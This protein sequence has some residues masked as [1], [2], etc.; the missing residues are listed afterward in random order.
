MTLKES[1]GEKNTQE[2]TLGCSSSCT[3][4]MLSS[5]GARGSQ[6]K[7]ERTKGRGWQLAPS[8]PEEESQPQRVAGY[9]LQ[10]FQL[11]LHQ[12][13]SCSEQVAHQP[14][15]SVILLWKPPYLSLRLIWKLQKTKRKQNMWESCLLGELQPWGMFSKG[16]G[17]LIKHTRQHWPS[18][19]TSE[20]LVAASWHTLLPIFDRECLLCLFWITQASTGTPRGEGTAKAPPRHS[21]HLGDTFQ[22]L[23]PRQ[24]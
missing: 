7:L 1:P 21:F 8:S 11:C 18:G 19:G 3:T 20:V 13:S 5:P 24:E 17:C 9:F 23:I 6:R 12:M 4:S 22:F 10:T 16:K 14:F 2:T 15:S